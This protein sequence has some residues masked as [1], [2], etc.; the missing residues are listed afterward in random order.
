MPYARITGTR[1]GAAAIRYA[2]GGE[3]ENEKGHNDNE[4]RNEYIMPVNMLPGEAEPYDRQ[5]DRH[6]RM[7]SARNKV[8]VRRIIISFSRNEL[9]PDNPESIMR[10]AQICGEFTKEN[11]PGRQ[12]LVCIQTDGKS[13]L[14]HGHILV[15]NVSF[16]A[17]TVKDALVRDHKN[18]EGKWVYATRD[19]NVPAG[20]G[21]L[22]CQT[23]HNF[24]EQRARAIAERYIDIDPGKEN[25]E[26]LTQAERA[27]R[28]AG[29]YVYKDDLRNRIRA[30]RDEA[31]SYDNFLELLPAHGI[32]L[33]RQGS[34][35]KHGDYLTYEQTDLAIFDPASTEYDPDAKKP[36]SFQCRSYGLGDE[37]CPDA[38][39]QHIHA[40]FPQQIHEAEQQPVTREAR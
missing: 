17:G 38:I 23:N 8:Q 7:A 5:M 26:R 32:K 29:E 15:N 36:K 25:R 22:D 12:A 3:G 35:K 31:T 10:A 39:K 14:V 19:V 1:N 2:L 28:A 40:R 30:A 11:Y 33:N 21:C 18:D 13:G 20:R 16:D 27:K 37:F 6:W 4:F 9:D 34:S 24:V